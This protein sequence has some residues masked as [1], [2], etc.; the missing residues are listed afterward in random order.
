MLFKPILLHYCMD[1]L[2]HAP[3]AGSHLNNCR[4]E[5]EWSWEDEVYSVLPLW[6]LGIYTC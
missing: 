2:V 6:A 3:G 1:D 5:R 4:N